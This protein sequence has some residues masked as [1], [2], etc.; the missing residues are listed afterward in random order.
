MI[1]YFTFSD[2]SLGY[3]C[4][5]CGQRCCRGKT[6]AIDA[7]ELVPLLGRQPRLARH[8]RLGGGGTLVAQNLTDRCWFL[9]GDGY[10]RIE[11]EDGRA[12]KPSTCRLFPFNRVFRIGNV[13]VV[14][15]NSTLCPIELR[16][17][18]G[19]GHAEIVKDL[20]E[21][22]RSP[23]VESPRRSPAGL[24]EE[25]WRAEEATQALYREH[26]DSALAALGAQGD[27]DGERLLVAWR[28]VYGLAPE[29]EAAFAG[30]VAERVAALAGT[31][32]FSQLFAPA[33]SSGSAT[34][35]VDGDAAARDYVVEAGLLPRRL[36]ALAFLGTLAA[37]LL[38]EA[39]SLRGLTEL[40]HGQ[41]GTLD[42]LARWDASVKIRNPQFSADLPPLLQPHL[43]K[44]LGLGFRGGSSLGQIVATIADGCEPAERPL[45]VALAA[46]QLAALLG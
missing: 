41:R 39:P 45:V 6:F 17:P 21:I 15:F 11:A 8:L 13:R 14:D 43:G 19:V 9:Q 26:A 23:L 27:L 30:K 34:A 25:W 18:D 3:D 37:D 38:D 31:L 40:W 44:L 16:T 22:G 35:T 29:R 2:G 28:A 5:A 1:T 24:P 12:A 46:S 7:D 20:D 42:V 4:A 10:C 32:R 36:F 33:A